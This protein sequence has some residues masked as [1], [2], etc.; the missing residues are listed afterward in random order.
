MQ[1]RN[2]L[3]AF[4]RGIPVLSLPEGATALRNS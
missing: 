2:L 1:I 4:S 3:E